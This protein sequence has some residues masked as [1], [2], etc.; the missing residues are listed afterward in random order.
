MHCGNELSNFLHHRRDSLSRRPLHT[1]PLTLQPRIR[2]IAVHAARQRFSGRPYPHL[3][4][5]LPSW[6]RANFMPGRLGMDRSPL[7]VCYGR[8]ESVMPCAHADNLI[9]LLVVDHSSRPYVHSL[10]N[11]GCLYATSCAQPL[12]LA[13]YQRVGDFNSLG[14]TP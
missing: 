4:G 3:S 1:W 2:V 7:W 11:V 10:C 9:D 6:Y 14:K 12:V 5:S 8:F 13:V